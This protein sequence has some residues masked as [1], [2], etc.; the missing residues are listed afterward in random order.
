MNR[1]IETRG[2]G[3]WIENSHH[4]VW[5]IVDGSGRV[6]AESEPQGSQ[7]QTFFRSAAKPFQT[8]MLLTD[9]VDMQGTLSQEEIALACGSHVGSQRHVGLAQQILVKANATESDLTCGVHAPLCDEARKNTKPVHNNCSGKHAAMLYLCHKNQWPKETYH[10]QEHPLQQAIEKG[11]QTLTGVEKSIPVGVDGC[12]V[13]TFYMPLGAMAQCYAHLANDENLKPVY[14]AMAEYPYVFGGQGRID[15]ELTAVSE[16]RLVAKVG[17]DGLICIA[18]KDTQY[19]LAF[20]VAHGGEYIRNVAICQF[21][22][23]LGWLNQSEFSD[24]RLN[25]FNALERYNT[26]GEVVGRI[27]LESVMTVERD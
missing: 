3:D 14:G 19:G 9:D 12:G 7:Y 4:I 20:K 18:Y 11:L 10:E 25:A 27:R 8:V 23:E 24:K 17:A 5:A 22:R 6:L 21:L 16:G 15:S 1:L 2:D 26:C 13:P